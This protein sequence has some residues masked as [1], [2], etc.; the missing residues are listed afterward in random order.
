MKRVAG[1]T[2][3]SIALFW[4]SAE[5]TDSGCWRWKLYINRGGYG[6]L[7]RQGKTYRAHRVAYEL[8][9]GLLPEGMNVDH[10]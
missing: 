4:A 2:E 1:F 10:I 5:K 9:K 6:H 7:N 8:A 3:E